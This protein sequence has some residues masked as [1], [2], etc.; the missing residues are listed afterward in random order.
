MFR[1]IVPA[2]MTSMPTVTASAMELIRVIGSAVRPN[3]A[4]ELR[5]N[6]IAALPKAAPSEDRV[7]APMHV[8]ALPAS[9]DMV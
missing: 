7:S 3:A 6:Q 5:A 1:G 2:N 9:V 4:I 8:R